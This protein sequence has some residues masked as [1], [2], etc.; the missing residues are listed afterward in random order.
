MRVSRTFLTLTSSGSYFRV[1][2]IE[3]RGSPSNCLAL[4]FWEGNEAGNFH[5]FGSSP[6]RGDDSLEVVS[7]SSRGLI[8]FVIKAKEKWNF[9]GSVNAIST[10]G[11]IFD[12]SYHLQRVSLNFGT[13]GGERK[14]IPRDLS[15]CRVLRCRNPDKLILIFNVRWRSVSLLL[16]L[17]DFTPSAFI[18][19]GSMFANEIIKGKE[20]ETEKQ[21]E[22]DNGRTNTHHVRHTR[23]W[24]TD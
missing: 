17:L 2:G 21:G 10:F 15:G 9:N 11:W 19:L 16:L 1:F 20:T 7:R 13:E 24:F 8:R 6:S 5:F 18:R 4:A 12:H 22:K 14:P 23:R 3:F